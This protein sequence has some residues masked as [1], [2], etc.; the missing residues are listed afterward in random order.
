[1]KV[2]WWALAAVGVILIITK[3]A[4]PVVGNP[5]HVTSFGEAFKIAFLGVKYEEPRTI[6]QIDGMTA[7]IDVT[8]GGVTYK[9]T[10]GKI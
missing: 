1:M 8:T 7:M 2:L 10:E 6:P 5:P 3:R 9:P 4:H